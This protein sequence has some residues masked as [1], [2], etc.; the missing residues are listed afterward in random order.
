[1]EKNILYC[2]NAFDVFSEIEN[3]SVDLVFTDPPY[4]ISKR[5]KISMKNRDIR[6]DFGE[7]DYTF[8][9]QRFMKEVYR[10]LV[11]QGSLIAWCAEQQIEN[12]CKIGRDLGFTM[13]QLLYWEKS[14]PIPQFRKVGY[15]QSMEL[16]IWFIKGI[17]SQSNPNWVFLKQEEMKDVF[18]HPI[19]AGANRIFYLDAEGNK[20]THPTQ[21]PLEI[22]REIIKR[23]SRNGGVVLDPF[24]GTGTIPL[25][26]KLEGR[27]Y[28]G[29]ENDPL[30]FAIGRDRIS[31]GD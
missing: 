5:D 20:I 9:M 25:A 8:D 27:N 1:M 19:V 16:M 6:L 21:K 14:N 28:I 15:R 7:W 10:V 30:W 24:F 12:Y 31:N 29:V 4:N 11:P 3:N 18:H 22:C 26:A 17:N 23:H 13:K 2:G